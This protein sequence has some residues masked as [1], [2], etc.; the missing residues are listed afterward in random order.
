[1][2]SFMALARANTLL[3]RIL[4]TWKVARSCVVAQSRPYWVTS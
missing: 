1:M 4:A 3:A 2:L